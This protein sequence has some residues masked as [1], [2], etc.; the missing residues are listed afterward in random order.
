VDA[1]C[2][3]QTHNT[4][5]EPNT[6]DEPFISALN[7]VSARFWLTLK[8]FIKSI[9]NQK[10]TNLNL[11]NVGDNVLLRGVYNHRPAYVQ[12]LRVVKDTPKETA[13]LIWPGAECAAPAGYIHLGHYAWDRWT[14]T[15]TNTLQLEKYFWRTNRFLVLLEPEKFYSTIYIWNAA[16]NKFV[17]YYINFQLP[18]RRTPL[19]FDT[20]DLDLDL[21]I[22]ASLKWKWKDEDEYQDG[23]RRGGIQPDWV[24]E[25]EHAQNEVF[26][27]IEKRAYPLDASWLNWQPNPTWSAPYLPQNWAE[28]NY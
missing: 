12:S 19:G 18:F 10:M 3:T 6:A 7:P 22:E 9:E 17:C 14:E 20:F 2:T 28:V 23:I 15:L 8:F 11:W 27:K 13:L 21:V 5:H 24:R 16:S 1:P 4:F 25:V 26:A